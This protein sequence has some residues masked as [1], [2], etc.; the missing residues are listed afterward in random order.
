M[1][2][3]G[4]SIFTILTISVTC[5]L[6]LIWP[7]F[8]KSDSTTFNTHPL[9]TGE[10]SGLEAEARLAEFIMEMNRT[11][12]SKQTNY[13]I[14]NEFIQDIGTTRIKNHLEK[15][16]AACHGISHDLGKVIGEREPDLHK[17]MQIC[18]D[19]CTYGCIH[20]VFKIY[21]SKLGKEY[22]QAH[23]STVSESTSKN[24]K[25][26]AEEESHKSLSNR[27]SKMT[28]GASSHVGKGLN[29]EELEKF[30]LD[31]ND[32]CSN[33][34]SV[35]ADFFRGNCAHGVGHAMG[36]LATN[37]AQATKYCK[38]FDGKGMQYYCETGVFMELAKK[39]KKKLYPVSVN[40]KLRLIAAIKYCAGVSETPSSCLRFLV[41]RT[42]NVR[43]ANVF[44][45]LCRQEQ[46]SA[47][48]GC[49]NALGF[50]SRAFL[51]K[52]PK[53]VNKICTAEAVQDRKAC[54]SGFGYMKKGHK[55]RSGIRRACNY[56]RD[57]QLKQGCINQVQQYYY[58]LNNRMFKSLL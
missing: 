38:V 30:A 58:Q 23:M 25:L 39:I 37:V 43:Q 56:L 17:G 19:T 2:S 28:M 35:V 26:R 32:A 6:L 7:A 14:Y 52:Y 42:K 46:G 16:N 5:L 47:R 27:G 49:F 36:M 18:A 1:Y 10:L 50:S 29:K 55:Y 11:G 24:G 21:F 13:W 44:T 48:L 15:V 41:W 12:V 9:I 34:I 4:H 51:A 45:N 31:V 8:V 3:F 54:V 57:N 53:E 20:G 22:H 33:P 40:R